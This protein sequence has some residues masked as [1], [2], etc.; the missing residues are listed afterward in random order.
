MNILTFQGY[1]GTA[2]LDMERGVC[3][4]KILFIG[5]LVTYEADSPKELQ[6]AFEEAV[7][8]YVDTCK[9][10]GK[11]P[12]RAFRGSFNVRVPAELHR[13]AT[14]RGVTDEMTLNEVVVRSLDCYLNS[15]TDVSHT[16][17]VTFDPAGADKQLVQAVSSG[18][19]NWSTAVVKH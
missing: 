10:V 9:Q 1:E 4:G 18:M 19:S 3:R 13:N 14:L 8:D 17:K 2:E 5:D 6:A 15:R 12:Q 11:E 16:I 7:V